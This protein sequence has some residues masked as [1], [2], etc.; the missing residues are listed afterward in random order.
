VVE[1]WNKIPASLKQAKNVRCFKNGYRT[2]RDAVVENNLEEDEE[3]RKSVWTTR[4]AWQSG[5]TEA[6]ETQPS[7][8]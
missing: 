8:I 7:S 3:T 4:I 6:M 5:P 1:S 2:L